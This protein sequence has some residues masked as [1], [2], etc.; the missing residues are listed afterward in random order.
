[1]K[2]RDNAE[3]TVWD[4]VR[5]F[6]Q[7]RVRVLVHLD[8][9]SP[10]EV[11]T[12]DITGGRHPRE[13][14]GIWDAVGTWESARVLGSPDKPDIHFYPKGEAAWHVSITPAE[15]WAGDCCYRYA[16]AGA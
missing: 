8:G 16:G 11:P 2:T 4:V 14:M 9:M 5:M 10:I 13:A 3:M 6:G 7:G 1:M 12:E 15:E